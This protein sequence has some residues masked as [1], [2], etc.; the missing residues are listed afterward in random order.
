LVKVRVR[1]RLGFSKKIEEMRVK[2]R[3]GKKNGEGK[4]RK[5]EN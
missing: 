2:G 4:E 5:V 3:D 1:F